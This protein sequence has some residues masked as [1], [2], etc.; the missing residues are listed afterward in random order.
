MRI[1]I[2]P[3]LDPRREI[4]LTEVLVSAIAEELWRHYGGNEQLNWIEAEMHLD[5]LVGAP[6][7]RS[8]ELLEIGVP[9]GDTEEWRERGGDTTGGALPQGRTASGVVGERRPRRRSPG[10][11]PRGRGRTSKAARR[12]TRRAAPAA[13]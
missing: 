11:K 5:N 2:R 12:A 10:G 6:G 3:M 8:M 4:D 9:R 13:R 7:T 1:L